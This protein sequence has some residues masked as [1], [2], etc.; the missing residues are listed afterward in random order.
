MESSD[1]E[2]ERLREILKSHGA[3]Q[4][5]LARYLNLDTSA[6]SRGLA[7]KRKFDRYERVRI[8]EFV[9]QL[10]SES[11]ISPVE[12]MKSVAERSENLRRH[13][14]RRNLT[15]DQLSSV[16]GV[17]AKDI[18]LYLAAFGPAMSDQVAQSLSIALG[19]S[20]DTQPPAL[21][22]RR[23][24][25]AGRE[26][27]AFREPPEEVPIFE[28]PV[29]REGM[30]FTCTF[31]IAQIRQVP[32]GRERVPHAF[33]L[34]CPD[35]GL[36]PKFEAGEVLFIHPG[37]SVGIGHHALVFMDANAIAIG[38]VTTNDAG[39]LTLALGDRQEKLARQ[40]V[41]KVQ[42]IAGMWFE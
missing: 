37:R 28:A 5:M 12:P 10:Q 38:R 39:G 26:D 16:S 21:S 40:S 25:A 4:G 14:L 42:R 35:Y 15:V 6:V 1:P 36:E 24:V 41:R 11:L 29:L 34:L 33:G 3:T 32:A 19:E 17:N 31:T 27:S 2:I 23:A 7:G 18:A 8:K 13:M 30:I 20:L 22:K 9:K